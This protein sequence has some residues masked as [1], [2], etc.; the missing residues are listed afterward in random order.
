MIPAYNEEE[1]IE[2]VVE[3]IKRHFPQYDYVIIN[4]GSSDRTSE[5]CHHNHYNIID[6][7]KILAYLVL[8]RRALNMPLKRDMLKH[9][10]SMQMVNTCQSILRL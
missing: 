2:K 4:D 6:L 1:S 10:S 3:N 5:I 7:P 8:F 9:S